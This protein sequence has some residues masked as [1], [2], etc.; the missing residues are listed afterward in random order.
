M[1]NELTPVSRISITNWLVHASSIVHATH[2]VSLLEIIMWES[3]DGVVVIA[4][5]YHLRDQGSG[6]EWVK[7]VVGSLL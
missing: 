5:A 4:L 2:V 6:H 7:L 1:I 3:R